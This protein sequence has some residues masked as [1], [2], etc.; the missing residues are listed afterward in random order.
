MRIVEEFGQWLVG[1]GVKTHDTRFSEMIDILRIIV[2]HYKD[3]NMPELFEKYDEATLYVVLTE[4]T[5]FV[6]IFFAFK[7]TK[8]HKL[9]RTKFK[10]MLKGPLLPWNESPDQ[11]NIQ[12]RN[13]LF[14]LEMAALFKSA[15]LKI[16]SYDDVEFRFKK[17]TFNVQC[18]RIHSPNMISENVSGAATQITRR[19]QGSNT[20]GLICICIDKLTE[21]EGWILQAENHQNAGLSLDQICRD[22]IHTNNHLW[23]NLVNTNILGTLIIMNAIAL[24]NKPD[25]L[26]TNC[27]QATMDIIPRNIIHQQSDYRLIKDLSKK[28]LK[29]KAISSFCGS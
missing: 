7:K 9:P 22:F 15:G 27:R 3:E 21:K 16:S 1:V 12:A 26:L 2:Q 24:L 25:S 29:P 19:M 18:K 13:T 28:L 14:E 23:Q 4:A 5:A 17:K 20:K 6:R 11:A 10:E 8:S